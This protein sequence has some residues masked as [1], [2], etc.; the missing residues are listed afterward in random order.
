[1]IITLLILSKLDPFYEALTGIVLLSYIL[2]Y[3]L[4]LLR[5]LDTPFDPRSKTQDS[6]SMFL[7]REFR[8]WL[9]EEAIP[10]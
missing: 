2:I 1:M 4:K 8:E 3:V 9:G 5:R 6:M 7:L 10:R